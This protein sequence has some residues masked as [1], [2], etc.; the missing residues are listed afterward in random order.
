M[1]DNDLTGTIPASFHNLLQL[2]KLRLYKNGFTGAISDLS[3]CTNLDDLEVQKNLFSGIVPLWLGNLPKLTTIVLSSNQ[4]VGSV[5]SSLSKLNN[6][7]Y[8]RLQDKLGIDNGAALQ[9]LCSL[10]KPP[11]I[12]VDCQIQCTCCSTC[13]VSPSQV[14]TVSSNRLN[15]GT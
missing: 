6:L 1:G 11:A 7:E 10:S 8:L 12:I 2:H 14:T 13:L 9:D 4:F 15:Q 3:E 5:P